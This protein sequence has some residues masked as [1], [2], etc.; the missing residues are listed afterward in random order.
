MESQPVDRQAVKRQILD[1]IGKNNQ[2]YPPSEWREMLI[3]AEY[4]DAR[5]FD[6]VNNRRNRFGNL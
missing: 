1:S 4:S 2:A 3:R 5:F 6:F